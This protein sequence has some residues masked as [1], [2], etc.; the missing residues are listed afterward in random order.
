M[1]R[2]VLM[3]C[4]M[5]IMTGSAAQACSASSL[6][7]AN[8]AMNELAQARSVRDAQFAA[9]QALIHLRMAWFSMMECCPMAAF[10]VQRAMGHLDAISFERSAR[11]IT[12][13]REDAFDAFRQAVMNWNS[14]LF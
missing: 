13:E 11:L 2:R 7:M 6:N 3:V 10:A 5:V 9:D 1:L 12:I 14:R 8:P 4:G